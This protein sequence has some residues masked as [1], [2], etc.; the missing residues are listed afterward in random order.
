MATGVIYYDED[1]VE[2][3]QKAEV[4]IVACNGIGTPRLVLNS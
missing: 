3:E 1:G 4:V 2:Q